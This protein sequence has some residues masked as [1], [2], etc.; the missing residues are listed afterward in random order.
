MPNVR[1]PA[2]TRDSRARKPSEPPLAQVASFVELFVWLLVLKSFFLPLFII[3][4]GSMAE[5]LMG[6]YALHLCP[7]CGYEYPINYPNPRSLHRGGRPAGQIPPL[8]RC[9]NCRLLED[10]QRAAL[11]SRAGDRI[12]VHGWPYDFDGGGL[13][14]QRWDVVVFRY[15]VDNET[16]FIKR[17]IGLPGEKIEII[18]GDIFVNDEIVR[19]PLGVQ[20]TLWFNSYD[21]DYP[22]K[23]PT[24]S[25]YLPHWQPLTSGWSG[26][27]TKRMAF[28]A[29]GGAGPVVIQ[30][31]TEPGERPLPGQVADVYGYNPPYAADDRDLRI[32]NDVRVGAVVDLRGESAGYVELA[33]TKY[34]DTFTARLERGGVLRL[35]RHGVGE[36]ERALLLE[37]PVRVAGPVRF[38]L[39]IADYQAVVTVGDR[40]FTAPYDIAAGQA[41]ERAMASLRERLPVVQVRAGDGASG[42]LGHVQLDRDEYYTYAMINPATPGHGVMN[43]PIT[44]G[45]DAFFML[46][47]NSPRSSDGRL[48]NDVGP[49]FA[50]AYAAGEYQLGTVPRSQLIGRAFLVYWPGFMPLF[51]G[52]PNLLPDAG[53]IR[54][55]D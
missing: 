10:V 46:G 15:P 31:A 18:D 44:L 53:H 39:G 24:G 36:A 49:Q 27:D 43:N 26:L 21:H 7:N 4:T 50:E 13:A 14:P 32:V 35:E 3:P 48:W 2:A 30:F 16:N 51:Q 11:S 20:E 8:I 38:A 55:I 23:Q 29:G 47:D 5:T 40:H 19:K 12:M 17:L 45:P 41:R 33:I 1:Q 9:P 25:G 22:P 52:G 6:E 42:T 34:S 28:D 54:W 37:A